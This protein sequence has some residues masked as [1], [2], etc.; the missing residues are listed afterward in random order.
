MIHCWIIFNFS[1]FQI[2]PNNFFPTNTCSKQW[3]SR[4]SPTEKNIWWLIKS[5]LKSSLRSMYLS[6]PLKQFR[7]LTSFLK[8][9]ILS[10][11]PIQSQS[12]KSRPCRNGMHSVSI[13]NIVTERTR[14]LGL[15]MVF[16][17][18][19]NRQRPWPIRGP[20]FENQSKIFVNLE[21]SV[22]MPWCHFSIS[23]LFKIKYPLFLLDLFKS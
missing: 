12:L 1:T 13:T 4:N 5:Y 16:K 6:R 23:L 18:V 10:M 17:M 22:I 21:T 3:Q 19:L 20:L 2:C 8:T 7:Q 11:A 9:V 15:C 14:P